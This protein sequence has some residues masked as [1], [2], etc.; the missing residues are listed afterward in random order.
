LWQ[1]VLLTC[2]SLSWF[3]TSSLQLRLCW[4]LLVTAPWLLRG[5]F[6]VNHFSD[7]YTR[8]DER[9][10]WLVRLLYRLK[11]YQY[12][13]YKHVLFHGLNALAALGGGSIVGTQDFALYWQVLNQSYVMEFFLQTLVKKQYMA[14]WEMLVHNVALM[15]V[16]TTCALNVRQRALFFVS[17]RG[18]IGGGARDPLDGGPAE[19]A[20]Q[21]FQSG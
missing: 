14:Q 2:S 5:L 1:I 13:L 20:S 12:L 10:N 11:K 3:A 15:S 8:V 7:N 6:P 21:F 4:W 19:L 16:A 17:D 9:S 18:L